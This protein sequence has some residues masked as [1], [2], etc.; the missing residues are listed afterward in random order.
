MV[1]IKK[2]LSSYSTW[3]SL[4][5]RLMVILR[6]APVRFRPSRE[7]RFPRSRERD[8]TISMANAKSVLPGAALALF[9]AVFRKGSP[10]NRA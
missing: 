8:V 9:T 3:R 6:P 4:S 7:G 5:A 1:Y 10:L 2:R